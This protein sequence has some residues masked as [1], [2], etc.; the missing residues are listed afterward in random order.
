MKMIVATVATRKDAFIRLAPQANSP[1]PITVAF[2]NLRCATASTIARTT[3][4]RT[5]RTSAVLATLHVPRTI[6][7]AKRLT[8]AWNLT[9]CVTVTTIAATIAMRI[10]ST[11]LREPAHRTASDAPITGKATHLM[12]DNFDNRVIYRS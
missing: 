1:A 12:N 8:F 5:R 9:G 3:S 4:L 10:R 7:N 2:L 11:V 6:S